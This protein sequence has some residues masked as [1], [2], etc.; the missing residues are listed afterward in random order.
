[1][2]DIELRDSKKTSRKGRKPKDGKAMTPAERKRQQRQ[3]QRE[4]KCELPSWL[5]LRRDLWRLIQDHFMLA[6]V[7]ELADALNAL[8]A[9]LVGANC[10]RSTGDSTQEWSVGLDAYWN[11]TGQ[12][13]GKWQFLDD[14]GPYCFDGKFPNREGTKLV[15]ILRDVMEGHKKDS[16][17]DK[18]CD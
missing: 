18:P 15:D 5:R 12:L 1:M 4:A 2:S 11:A 14:F 3:R 9:A 16:G 13:E 10:F 17:E 7:D 6:D 8:Q